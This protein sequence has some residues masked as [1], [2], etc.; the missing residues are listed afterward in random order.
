MRVF[1]AVLILILNL[2]SWTKADDI[3]DFEI[4]GMSI[5]DSLLDYFSES[6]ILDN[7]PNWFK[8]NEYSLANDL[9]LE[10]FQTYLSVQA[11]YKTKDKKYIL[12]GIEGYKF[13]KKMS[14]CLKELDEVVD[15]ISKIASGTVRSKKETYKHNDP[16]SN[17]TITSLFF[18][19]DSGDRI[20]IGCANYV[21]IN[22]PVDLRVIFRTKE[23]SYFISHKAYK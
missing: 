9:R 2:Q 23:Y 6:E 10:T 21:D 1:I 22:P 3:R 11:A 17:A 12:E 13:Y 19:F 20:S 16:D 4:E 5:G 18:T 14:N 8:D 7:K 15:E